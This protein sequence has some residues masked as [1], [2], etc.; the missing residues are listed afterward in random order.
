M[1][2]YSLTARTIKENRRQSL[3]EGLRIPFNRLILIQFNTIFPIRIINSL[4]GMNRSLKTPP[5]YLAI[6]NLY[7]DQHTYL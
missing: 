3:K 7:I 4:I 6:H 5:Y 1:Y 2:N